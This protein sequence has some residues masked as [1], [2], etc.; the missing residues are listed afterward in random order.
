MSVCHGCATCGVRNDCYRVS[1]SGALTERL[2]KSGGA[3]LFFVGSLLFA[4]TT[5]AGSTPFVFSLFL[6]GHLC[7]LVAGAV[8]K[9]RGTLL[10]NAMYL[11]FD[12][13]AVWIRL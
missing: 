10:S 3:V 11:V 9:D 5:W 12:V 8:M 4:T 2:V 6:L 13:S 7:W 1:A